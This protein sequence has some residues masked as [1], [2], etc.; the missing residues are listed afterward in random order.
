[1]MYE[2]RERIFVPVC[3]HSKDHMFTFGP[4][5][6][7]EVDQ[8]IECPIIVE[9]EKTRLCDEQKDESKTADSW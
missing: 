3:K 8:L 4:L 6:Y 2:G 1:M 9:S 7:V 5:G